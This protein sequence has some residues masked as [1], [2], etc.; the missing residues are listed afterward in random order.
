MALAAALAF[1]LGGRD[2]A[3]EIV[4]GWY[5]SGRQAAPKAARAADIAGQRVEQQASETREAMDRPDRPM[6]SRGAVPG[7]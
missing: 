4:A 3:A 6:P 1:G 7:D 5:R 2:T